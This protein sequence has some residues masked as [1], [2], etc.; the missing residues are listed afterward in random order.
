MKKTVISGAV[1]ALLSVPAMTTAQAQ[2]A[3]NAS[4]DELRQTVERLESEV[5]YLKENAKADR[6]DTATKAVTLETLNTTVS[7]FTWSGDLRYRHED[8]RQEGNITNRERDRL[9]L[10]FG[11]LAKVNDTINAKIQLSTTNTGADNARS[12]NQTLGN[13]TAGNGPWDRKPLSIDLAY[14]EWKPYTPVTVVLGKISIPWTTTTS[15]FW[16]KDLTPEGG[17]V[18]FSKGAWF[19]DVGYHWLGEQNSGTNVARSTDSKMVSAQFGL[20]Q[21]IGKTT[22]TAAVGYFDV[23]HVQD[24]PI[25]V[26]GTIGATCTTYTAF[27]PAF[28]SDGSLGNTTKTVGGCNLLASDFNLIEAQAQLDFM[29]GK[30][31]ISVFVDFLKNQG[32][33]EYNATLGKLDTA[34]SA[35]FLFNKA[36]AAKSWEAGVVYQK[37][38]KDSMF[39]QFH[40]SDFGGGLVDTDGYVVKAAYV[41]ATGWTLNAQ[42]IIN[43]RN[44]DVAA[45]NGTI[46][47]AKTDHDY[48]RLQLDL[49]YKF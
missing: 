12:T 19:G 44:N 33:E 23:Q 15:Y 47:V 28:S 37:T 39:A 13:A 29:A 46:T 48:K 43:K 32:A 36:S 17:V 1:V 4:V 16:D 24:Q 5:E 2:N 11:V 30:F 22:L 10:R 20:K 3:G 14:V 49:N 25:N 7:K 41:P 34:M 27:N 21:P 38:E 40:D 42:Y 18:K 31:P 9:R 35:G 8:I 26:G 6:K 45:T